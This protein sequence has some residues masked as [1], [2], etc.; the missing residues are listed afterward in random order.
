MK[1]TKNQQHIFIKILFSVLVTQTSYTGL[2][3]NRVIGL[4]S[5]QYFVILLTDRVTVMTNAQSHWY[6][7]KSTFV[8]SKQVQTSM[9]RISVGSFLVIMHTKCH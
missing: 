6:D 4:L 3:N 1:Q 9:L 8:P 5:D 7:L 2:C